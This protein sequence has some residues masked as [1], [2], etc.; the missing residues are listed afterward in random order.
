MTRHMVAL[1]ATSKHG[2]HW[3]VL[4]L[5]HCYH[6]WKESHEE[7]RHAFNSTWNVFQ[8]TLQRNQF[9]PFTNTWWNPMCAV[10]SPTSPPLSVIG[11]R[12]LSGV[13]HLESLQDI[14]VSIHRDSR[15]NRRYF[16]PC[17]KGLGVSHISPS[18]CACMHKHECVH[19]TCTTSHSVP[20]DHPALRSGCSSRKKM[21]KP[22]SMIGIL[23]T[24]VTGSPD[25][26]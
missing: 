16:C 3:L 23:L 17:E 21:R 20:A 5:S 4:V 14:R 6:E 25:A 19:T 1:W 18:S 22:G 11:T 10:L 9:E 24:Q 13:S 26:V 12:L 15:M 7:Q 2:S 8:P